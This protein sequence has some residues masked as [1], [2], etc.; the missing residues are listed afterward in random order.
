MAQLVIAG[1][2]PTNQ[3]ISGWYHGPRLCCND[4]RAGDLEVAQ[5]VL[6]KRAFQGGFPDVVVWGTYLELRGENLTKFAQKMVKNFWVLMYVI[7]NVML[8]DWLWLKN[9]ERKQ[10]FDCLDYCL[11]WS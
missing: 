7:Q 3:K 10:V 1:F 9:D 4:L 2:V 6:K 11:M 5:S 8:Y